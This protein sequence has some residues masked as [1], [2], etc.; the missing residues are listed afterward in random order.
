MSIPPQ[1]PHRKLERSRSDR[2]LG[3][4][5]GGV[6]NYLNV[7]VTLVRVLTVVVA[8]STGVPIILYLLAL[9]L[10]PE[11]GTRE[12]PPGYPPVGGA[13]T[14]NPYPYESAP[15]SPE[16]TY[17]P[18]LGAPGLGSPDPRTQ[19]GPRQYGV[20]PTTPDEAIWGP[21]GAPWQQPQATPRW[22]QPPATPGGQPGPAPKPASNDP[23]EDQRD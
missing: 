12:P 21:G 2:V 3:G 10:I 22:Q 8:L 4:V 14:Y 20:P 11:E 13:W 9:L 18:G 1:Q 6:A 7:D 19:S 15:E 16:P 17:F 5:C 23:A